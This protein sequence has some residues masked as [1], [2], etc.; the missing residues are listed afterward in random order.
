MTRMVI[1]FALG[2]K[3]KLF[4][5][6]FEPSVM[7]CITPTVSFLK[8]RTFGFLLMSKPSAV[9]W[10]TL[11]VSFAVKPRNGL[12]ESPFGGTSYITYRFER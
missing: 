3:L 12:I 4:L 2:E 6:M 1:G 9:L 7:L 11:T 8:W 5:F 10:T